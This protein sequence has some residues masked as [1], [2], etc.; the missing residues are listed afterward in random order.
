[1]ERISAALMVKNEEKYIRRC[2]ESLTWVDE[3][4]ILDGFSTDHTVEIAREFTD[5]IYQGEFI[6]FPAERQ[7]LLSKCSN[8]WVFMVDADMV[9]PKELKEEIL[10]IFSQPV[11]EFAAFKLRFLNIYLGRQIRHCGWFELNNIRIVNKNKGVFDTH[12]K[13]LDEFQAKGKCGVMKNYLLHFTYNNSLSEHVRRLDRYSTLNGYDLKNK[14]CRIS[15]FNLPVYFI[16]KPMLV[17]LYKYFY[18]RGFLDGIP[19]LILCLMSSISYQLA[20]FK[21]WDLQRQKANLTNV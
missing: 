16:F 5:K 13:F 17:F 1:M 19:G 21:L 12:L 14:G 11:D 8:Q 20:Y 9:V 3:I 2:L 15:Y 6:G 10:K 4:V 7:F 18:K